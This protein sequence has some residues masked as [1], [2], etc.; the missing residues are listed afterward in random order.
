M[1]PD[2]NLR[3]NCA[4]MY[5]NMVLSFESFAIKS[6]G[7]DYVFRCESL[8]PAK[9]R[10]LTTFAD[11]VNFDAL[12]AAAFQIGLSLL[13]YVWMY[14]PC[15]R[16]VIAAG[17]LS[18]FQVEFWNRIYAEVL[19]EFRAV[20]KLG[21]G[22]FLLEVAP[23]APVCPQLC[24]EIP[25]N[26][27]VLVGLGAGKDSL[28]ASALIQRCMKPIRWVFFGQEAG[29]FAACPRYQELVR[30][31]GV[32]SHV[33]LQDLSL[34]MPPEW[35]LESSHHQ[36]GHPWACYVAFSCVLLAAVHG[37]QWVCLGNERSSNFEDAPGI[38]HQWDK[39][40][41]FTRLLN[42]YVHQYIMSDICI[43]FCPPSMVGAAD[44][45]A[46]LLFARDPLLLE[47]F[48]LLQYANWCRPCAMVW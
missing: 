29:Q 32:D 27:E 43:F 37:Q 9:V 28:V 23:H 8:P 31:S 41:E 24:I 5:S 7:V 42:Q 30:A 19:A 16:V 21:H 36:C 12:K 22:C 15:D 45:E 10:V 14:R 35:T 38:N 34:E 39:S 33:L 26:S 2:G 17:H 11:N 3:N 40:L 6:T 25:R 13:P 44:C 20:N 47:I 18:T 4:P 48:Y 1:N 46:F